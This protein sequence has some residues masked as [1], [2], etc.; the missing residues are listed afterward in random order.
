MCVAVTSWLVIG[1]E[2]IQKEGINLSL[3]IYAVTD[4]TT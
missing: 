2:V 1:G 3:T 4:I